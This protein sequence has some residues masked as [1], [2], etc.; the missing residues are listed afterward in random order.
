[1]GLCLWCAQVCFD[2]VEVKW[3]LEERHP[4]Q[5][6]DFLESPEWMDKGELKHHWLNGLSANPLWIALCWQAWLDAT[7]MASADGLQAS[8]PPRMI[9]MPILKRATLMCPLR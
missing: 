4:G 5:N 1:M 7:L 6:F 2:A 9:Q 3:A 8:H